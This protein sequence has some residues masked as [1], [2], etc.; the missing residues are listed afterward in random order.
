MRNGSTLYSK[1]KVVE[2]RLRLL[3]CSRL[4]AILVMLNVFSLY[5]LC[6]EEIEITKK[7]LT[8]LSLVEAVETALSHHPQIKIFRFRE[9]FAH[10][11]VLSVGSQFDPVVVTNIGKTV[12]GL[13]ERVREFQR[14]R[15]LSDGYT[16]TFS[17]AAGVQHQLRNSMS[18]SAGMGVDSVNQTADGLEALNNGRVNF[19]ITQPLLK[20]RG[21]LIVTADE[22]AA[23]KEMQ[24]SRYEVRHTI[25]G[26]VR[27]V[28]IAYWTYR[29][30]RDSL[31]I[32]TN[33]ENRA[34]QLLK[35][36]SELIA[37]GELPAA[38]LYQLQANAAQKTA[39][40]IQAQ[41]D[42]ALAGQS[43]VLALGLSPSE[44][45][46]V[47]L[48]TDPFPETMA[49]DSLPP[50][51]DLPRWLAVG[52]ENRDDYLAAGQREQAALRQMLAAKNRLWNRL[53]L[54]I[55]MGYD[56][57]NPGNDPDRNITALNPNGSGFDMGAYLVLDWPLRNAA[58]RGE[59]QRQTAQ[60]RIAELTMVE[61]ARAIEAAITITLNALRNDLAGLAQTQEAIALFERTLT[62]EK[63]KLHLG[64]ATILDLINYEDRLTGVQL[65]A[66]STRL[67][68]HI[69]VIQLRFQTGMLITPETDDVLGV[70][71]QTLVQIPRIR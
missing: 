39:T 45:T 41:Q 37:R 26:I 13:P 3:N 60:H 8:T 42:L 65:Q 30:S 36:T 7:D 50:I 33:S 57:V 9:N 68:Y 22:A 5:E 18:L 47:P 55:D 28:V 1:S 10:G 49:P 31:A 12:D 58:A 69:E 16:N 51:S 17:Y 4:L 70:D 15:G 61:L 27:D 25:S 11:V 29:A 24:A 44:L 6:S 52:V 38:E 32:V 71:Y 43:L 34:R 20:N 59:Y 21:R 48:P 23:E 14:S 19:S 66:L 35:E 62:N 56:N 64:E 46:V 54:R 53:D 63:Q 40:R 67:R 2:T